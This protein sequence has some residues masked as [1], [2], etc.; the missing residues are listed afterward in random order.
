MGR[1]SQDTLDKLN[2]FFESLPDEARSKCTICNETLTHIVK[3][4][5]AQTGAGTTTVCRALAERVN[6]N[7]AKWDVVSESKLRDRVRNKEKDRSLSG[8][9]SQIGQTIDTDAETG[10]AK[11]RKVSQPRRVDEAREHLKN[12]ETVSYE[13]D[14]AFR[15]M[16]AAVNDA[17]A[18]G[19]ISTTK[20]AA[21]NI[22]ESLIAIIEH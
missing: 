8:A 9:K 22:V 2:A 16:L 12:L 4:A 13:F 21:L 14:Q 7:A 1:V 15:G 18:E 5:E 17:K 3:Q 19:W 11:E 20:I 6:E 10:E